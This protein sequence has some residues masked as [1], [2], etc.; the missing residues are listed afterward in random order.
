MPPALRAAQQA[1][2]G[3]VR[4]DVDAH[5]ARVA[6]EVDDLMDLRGKLGPHLPHFSVVRVAKHYFLP[7]VG[8]PYESEDHRMRI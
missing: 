6:Q 1:E 2:V 4:V 7:I 3:V 5:N 8:E